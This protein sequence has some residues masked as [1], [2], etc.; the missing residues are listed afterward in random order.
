MTLSWQRI[1]EPCLAVIVFQTLSITAWDFRWPSPPPL[2][3]LPPQCSLNNGNVTVNCTMPSRESNLLCVT[4]LP[5]RVPYYTPSLGAGGRKEELPCVCLLSRTRFLS[6]PSLHRHSH[7]TRRR[8]SSP[9]HSVHWAPTQDKARDHRWGNFR[10]SIG[11]HVAGKLSSSS[12]LP[13]P[14]TH[15]FDKRVLGKSFLGGPVPVGWP[16]YGPCLAVS[17][18]GDSASL[19]FQTACPI[20]TF[21]PQV[22]WKW[23]G[24]G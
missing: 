13:T 2:P 6:C 4:D 21:Q 17:W 3:H 12:K 22:W 18:L 9:S 8:E 23:L 5:I 7:L 10:V 24:Q 11:C 16:S 15:L 19:S 14:C 20:A 1:L